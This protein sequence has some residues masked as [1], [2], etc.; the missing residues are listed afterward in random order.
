M[1]IRIPIVLLHLVWRLPNK[2]LRHCR[3]KETALLTHAKIELELFFCSSCNAT[4]F[5]FTYAIRA[6][7]NIT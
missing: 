4:A 5:K 1:P 7:V 2:T 3:K 6:T